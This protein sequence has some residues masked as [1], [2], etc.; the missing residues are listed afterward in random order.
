MDLTELYKRLG[1]LI[2]IR[3]SSGGARYFFIRIRKLPGV[4]FERGDT[5]LYFKPHLDFLEF[6]QAKAGYKGM[7]SKVFE[8][9]TELG[10][11]EFLRK[12]LQKFIVG[13]G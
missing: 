5:G 12:T 7:R 3:E 8:E 6:H 1:S 11:D 2:N 10:V 4:G 9:E 13:G